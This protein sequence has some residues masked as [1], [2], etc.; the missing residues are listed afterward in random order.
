MKRLPS[1]VST[2]PIQL[3]YVLCLTCLLLLGGSFHFGCQSPECLKD[4]DCASNHDSCKAGKCVHDHSKH[5]SDHD[6]GFGSLDPDAGDVHDSKEPMDSKD[7]KDS[8]SPKDSM[9]HE[10]HNEAHGP[11]K[12][13]VHDKAPVERK[14]D[15]N[16][17]PLVGELGRCNQQKKCK[18]GHRCIVFSKNAPEGICLRTMTSCASASCGSGFRCVSIQ[19]GGV[20]LRLCGA[21]QP[22]PNSLQCKHLHFPGG[23]GDACV[24]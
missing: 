16:T 2:R 13:Q 5:H 6:S 7:P 3:S 14:P 4:S 9:G 21:G 15:L 17:N 22:C 10:H 12:V 18:Q 24:P 1:V 20:C 11:D 23:H 19:S 8:V